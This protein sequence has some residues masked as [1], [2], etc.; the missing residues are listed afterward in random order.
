MPKTYKLKL[1]DERVLWPEQKSLA[2]VL[3]LQRNTPEDVWM[4]GYQ[5]DPIAEGGS[6]FN[7]K[8]WSN[9]D[10]NYDSTD[11]RIKHRSVARYISFDTAIKDE[12]SNDYTAYT[13]GELMPDY[14][15]VIREV[16]RLKLE[17]SDL[18]VLV[19]NIAS[20][21]A[22]DGKLKGVLIEDKGSGT[23]TLQTLRSHADSWLSKILFEFL[24][25]AS[26]RERARLITPFCKNGMVLLPFPNA[27]VPWLYDF[28]QELYQFP[29][30]PH[31]DMVDSF[32]QVCLWLEYFLSD[33]MASIGKGSLE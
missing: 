6:I 18:P 11:D 7:R 28:T 23:T 24:P 2:T 19:E 15:L 22:L 29:A 20:K 25:Q 12:E 33:G 27:N 5:G 17:S 30:A 9:P 14:R 31:D 4:A 26:K 16:G 8:W 13:V 32:V 10:A 1:H 21:Y 3:E